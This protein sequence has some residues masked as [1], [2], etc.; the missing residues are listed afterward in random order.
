[1]RLAEFKLEKWLNPKD[2]I[3]EYNLGASCVKALSLEDLFDLIGEDL[4]GFFNDELRKMSL[5]YGHFSGMDRLL[6][7]LS[8]LYTDVSPNNILTV[9][10][11]TGANNMVMNELIEP[12][13]N[14]VAFLPN[15]QQHYAIPESLGVEVRSLLLRK[16]D[17]YLPDID[18]LR[19]LVD[20]KTRLITLSNP[21][22][23]TGAFIDR[24][25]LA[26]V[27]GV[28]K[29]VGAFVLCDEIYRGLADEYMTSVVDVYERGIATSS[30]SK[31]FSMAGTRLGWVVTNDEKMFDRLENRRSYD[32]IC[33]GPFDELITAIAMEHSDKILERSKN[34]VR[35]NRVILD[36]WIST[37]PHL[38]CANESLGTTAF[39]TYDYD[40]E[41]EALCTDI[42]DKT[43]V[44]LCHGGCFD[45]PKAF[46][47]GYGFGQPEHFRKGLKI[48]GRYLEKLG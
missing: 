20:E 10:G 15:Y 2:P 38:S 47:L 1:M 45:V 35:P 25:L 24:D 29:K 18:A 26:K 8:T 6:Q 34:I 16:E 41:T 13:D 46:R 17:S 11:G 23:P 40:I 33:C 37:Q 14:V 9:H 44:L 21:N 3:A 43:G 39:F 19:A 30:M 4:D 48:L 22:N 28:A 32:T 42:F 5:H 27:A 7:A 31:V 12:G 36:D